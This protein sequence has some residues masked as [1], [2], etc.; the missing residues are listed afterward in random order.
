L[1]R[2]QLLTA[3]HTPDELSGTVSTLA[4]YQQRLSRP[5]AHFFAISA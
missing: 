2:Q 3:F 5:T 4:N 1:I